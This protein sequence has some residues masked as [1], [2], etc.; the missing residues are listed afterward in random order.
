MRPFNL[1]TNYSNYIQFDGMDEW[2][3]PKQMGEKLACRIDVLEA[4]FHLASLR[5]RRK[6]YRILNLSLFWTFPF[7]FSILYTNWDFSVKTIWLLIQCVWLV[8]WHFLQ[9]FWFRT[10][11]SSKW[12]SKRSTQLTAYKLT[13]LSLTMAKTKDCH[14]IIAKSSPHRH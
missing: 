4:T 5:R 10:H 7:T 14:G 8:V 12:K 6:E 11:L 9:V 1:P 3:L 2:R 13:T